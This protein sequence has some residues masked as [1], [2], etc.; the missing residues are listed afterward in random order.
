M[1]QTQIGPQ[2]VKMILTRANAYS[3]SI[4]GFGMLRLYLSNEVRLH[5]WHPDFAVKDVSTI[6]THPWDFTSH[7]IAGSIKNVI[8]S[9]EECGEI[10]YRQKIQCGIGGGAVGESCKVILH[11]KSIE[12]LESGQSYEESAEDIH[13][14]FPAPGT[15]TIVERRFRSDTEHANVYHDGIWV[16]AEPRQATPEEVT[17][18]TQVALKRY[19]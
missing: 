1:M 18:I 3:W 6:H 8:Y 15:V 5:V 16:S 12:V 10:F 7:I 9:E 13:E 11:E 2:L 17:A 4:Q 19:F 14:S